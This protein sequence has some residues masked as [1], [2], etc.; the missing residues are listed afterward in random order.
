[1]TGHEVTTVDDS[2]SGSAATQQELSDRELVA[3][4]LVTITEAELL[5]RLG[6]TS[7]YRL[8]ADGSLPFVRIGRARRIPRRA[9]INLAAAALRG[10]TRG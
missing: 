2:K 7:I 8:M 1:V 4:G 3:D 10:V 9:V 5:L 6:R